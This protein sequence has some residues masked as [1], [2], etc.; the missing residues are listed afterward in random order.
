MKKEDFSPVVHAT[1]PFSNFAIELEVF[2]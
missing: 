1:L 2:K